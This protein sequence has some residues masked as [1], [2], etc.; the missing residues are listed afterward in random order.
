MSCLSASIAKE[1][2]TFRPVFCFFRFDSSG[3]VLDDDDDKLS[4]SKKRHSNDQ[5]NRIDFYLPVK[6]W[7]FPG[8]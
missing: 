1:P 4:L 5:F 2:I 8:T 3:N 6:R 7:R